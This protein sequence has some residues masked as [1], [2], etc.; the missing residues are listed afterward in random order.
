[1]TLSTVSRYRAARFMTWN[2][3]EPSLKN[4]K[5]EN[6]LLAGLKAKLAIGFCNALSKGVRNMIDWITITLPY[7]WEKEI[8]DGLFVV[9]DKERKLEKATPKRLQIDGTHNGTLSIRTGRSVIRETKFL[10][11]SGNPIKFLQ[12]HNAYGSNDLKELVRQIIDRLCSKP[13]Y[14]LSFIPENDR[15][16]FTE[17]DLKKLGYDVPTKPLLD[18]TQEQ[19]EMWERGG[20]TI[21]RI[22][23]TEMVEFSSRAEVRRVLHVL[24][25]SANV[26]RRGTGSWD[27]GTLYFGQAKKGKRAL[28][29]TLK[30]YCKGDEMELNE[31]PQNADDY[32]TQKTPREWGGNLPEAIPHRDSI[33]AWADNK[34]RIELTLRTKELKKLGRYYGRE[35]T[36]LVTQELFRDY[37][38]RL[39]ISNAVC[40]KVEE[41]PELSQIYARTLAD[42]KRGTDIRQ[43]LSR[44]TF[45]RHK[46]QIFDV[47]GYDIATTPLFDPPTIDLKKLLKEDFTPAPMPPWAI[48]GDK[49]KLP[50]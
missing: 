11:V 13:V 25:Q 1:M 30:M 46:K 8:D 4:T 2:G 33:C 16:G 22:D 38:L 50:F 32:S 48:E 3:L 39:K 26:Q 45:A 34:L 15:A 18:P 6:A 27:N 35:W 7:E 5:S 9:Y 41:H 42:W 14:D 17:E 19:R 20:F 36:P 49:E 31:I 29:W 10:E 44:Q 37:L 47:T 28:P 40:D 12:G 21:S 24:R 23:L 43:Y